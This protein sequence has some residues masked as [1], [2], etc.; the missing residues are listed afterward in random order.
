ML[1]VGRNGIF[2]DLRDRRGGGRG[3]IPLGPLGFPWS[4]LTEKAWNQT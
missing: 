3:T 4:D 2:F 1:G